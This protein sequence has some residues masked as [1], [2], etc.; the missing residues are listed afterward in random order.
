MYEMEK[1]FKYFLK[2]ITLGKNQNIY[3]GKIN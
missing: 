2:N 1:Y 3:L